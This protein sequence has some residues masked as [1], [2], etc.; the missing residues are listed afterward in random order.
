MAFPDG[1]EVE[2]DARA[3]GVDLV[4]QAGGRDV[5]V[6][7]VDGP[8]AEPL[9]RL[10]GHDVRLVRPHA[11]G[12]SL[13]EPVTLVSDGSLARLAGAAGRESV[14]ARRFRMLFELSGCDAHEEDG[15]RGRRLRIGEAVLEVGGPV[16]RCAVTTRDPDTG[17]RDLDTLRL[18]RGYRGRR[19]RDGA[20]LFGVY[21][22]VERPG[23]VR[24]GDAVELV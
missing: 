4:C 18:I 14:D 16:D 1:T 22:T 12:A 17:R 23:V 3:T 21:A 19:E 15:W 11:I 8:W 7:V 20:I 5:A 6:R 2:G 24:V 10:A 9:S 13:T